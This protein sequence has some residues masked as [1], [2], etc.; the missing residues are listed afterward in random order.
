MTREERESPA[1]G[2]GQHV[3]AYLA[4]I[5]LQDLAAGRFVLTVEARSRLGDKVTR[6]IQF[7]IK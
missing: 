4:R 3:Y 5:P 1:G 7:T 6:E 2:S